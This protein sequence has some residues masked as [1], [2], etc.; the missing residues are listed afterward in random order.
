[1]SVIKIFTLPKA[2]DIFLIRII[3]SALRPREDGQLDFSMAGRRDT[4][5][6]ALRQCALH[7]LHT[8]F[9]FTSHSPQGCL[10]ASI[11]VI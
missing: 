9:N 4:S 10:Q 8:R 7:Y 3:I 1:M 2:N 11:E 5:F 6:T